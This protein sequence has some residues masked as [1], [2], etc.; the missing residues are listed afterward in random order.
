LST[1][2]A[3]TGTTAQYAAPV[4]SASMYSAG[5]NFSIHKIS[6][7]QFT[8]GRNVSTGGFVGMIESESLIGLLILAENDRIYG[9]L[10]LTDQEAELLFGQAFLRSHREFVAWQLL[11]A[12][13]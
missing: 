7:G 13:A 4:L 9:V 1:H 11:T 3:S 6:N 12:R 2:S 8:L 10:D 5:E